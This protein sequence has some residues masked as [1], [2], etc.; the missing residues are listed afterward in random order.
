M[1]VSEVAR[2][3]A[4]HCPAYYAFPVCLPSLEKNSTRSRQ[5][6]TRWKTVAASHISSMMRVLCLHRN[7]HE[8]R[9]ERE[10]GRRRE[11]KRMDG[12]ML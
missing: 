3:R 11:R 8:Q 4:E 6:C 1:N 5:V 7:N 9:R 12:W 10:K 2:K